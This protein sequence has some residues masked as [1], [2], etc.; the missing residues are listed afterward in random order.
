[1]LNFWG[2]CILRFF[3]KLSGKNLYDSVKFVIDVFNN[4]IVSVCGFQQI[5]VAR[6]V[7][8]AYKEV[9]AVADFDLF[10]VIE[11]VNSVVTVI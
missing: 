3:P 11:K 1:M 4:S 10:N 7:F 8:I 5:A 6:R 9:L 2:E